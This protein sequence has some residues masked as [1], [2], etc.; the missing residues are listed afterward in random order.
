M[1]VAPSSRDVI[2]LTSVFHTPSSPH[3]V[4]TF[5][6]DVPWTRTRLLRLIPSDAASEECRRECGQ[7]PPSLYDDDNGDD[8]GDD[9]TNEKPRTIR[10]DAYDWIHMEEQ[11]LEAIK[12]TM[13]TSKELH[14]R[15]VTAVAILSSPDTSTLKQAFPI[16]HEFPK[17]LR[18]LVIELMAFMPTTYFRLGSEQASWDLARCLVQT[19]SFDEGWNP[20]FPRRFQHRV[21]ARIFRATLD[22]N[23][24]SG[25]PQNDQSVNAISDHDGILRFAPDKVAFRN[26]SVFEYL[27]GSTWINRR[28][29]ETP[30][31][32]GLVIL[33]KIKALKYIESMSGVHELDK[34]LPADLVR[35]VQIEIPSQPMRNNE[36]FLRDVRCG[37]DLSRWSLMLLKDIE[38]LYL[39]L[40]VSDKCFWPMFLDPKRWLAPGV[41][42]K[43]RIQH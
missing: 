17:D 8:N 9:N 4:L 19:G 41:S 31:L 42:R 35:M 22:E 16:I 5:P 30:A 14:Q 37:K 6:S 39:E 36:R 43:K 12:A 10:H 24:A 28:D 3:I 27:P 23:T 20:L 33:H 32:Y 40:D 1:C 2:H 13:N 18:S 15:I 21:R 26:T 34:K 38:K 11:R 29:Y 25:F 7:P